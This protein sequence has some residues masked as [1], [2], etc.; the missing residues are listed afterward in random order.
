VLKKEKSAEISGLFGIVRILF[1]R[2][3]LIYFDGD[4]YFFFWLSAILGDLWT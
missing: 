1:V 4:G 2:T 3:F